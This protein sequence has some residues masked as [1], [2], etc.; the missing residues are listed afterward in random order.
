VTYNITTLSDWRHV[1]M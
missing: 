1:V